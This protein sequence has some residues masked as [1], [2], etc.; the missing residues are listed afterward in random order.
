MGLG[1]SRGKRNQRT[2]F[3]SPT[4]N[5]QLLTLKSQPPSEVHQISSTAYI[6]DSSS[7]SIDIT[8]LDQIVQDVDFSSIVNATIDFKSSDTS[9]SQG[10][11]SDSIKLK[12]KE[13][14]NSSWQDKY[15]VHGDSSDIVADI[16]SKVH[17]CINSSVSE[18]IDIYINNL[19]KINVTADDILHNRL[20]NIS[21]M[22]KIIINKLIQQ[23]QDLINK[24]ILKGRSK[25]DKSEIYYR[26]LIEEFI[27]K[28]EIEMSKHLDD[29]QKQMENEK[30]ILFISSQDNIKDLSIKVENAKK[31]FIRKLE[32]ST[33]EKRQEIL[34]KISNISMDKKR[35]PLGYEQLRKVNLDIYSTVGQTDC[36]NIPDKDK[37]IKDINN[38]KTHQPIKRTLYI[39]S[40]FH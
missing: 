7:E 26:K 28:L 15:F 6:L 1:F 23:R 25:M 13:T 18:D 12:Q 10:D 16:E 3:P 11:L 32:F 17:G 19:H 2:Q 21:S 38:G 37:F 31:E 5:S 8:S 33:R 35:Q 22:E 30:E 39:Q 9:L 24:I 29:L 4:V 36:D 40:N 34:D 20:S 14:Q 27:S